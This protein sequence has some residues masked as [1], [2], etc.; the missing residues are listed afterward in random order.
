M[1]LAGI[2]SSG[3]TEPTGLTTKIS[4]PAREVHVWSVNLRVDRAA[5]CACWDLLSPEEAEIAASYRF[6]NDLRQFVV[7]RSLVRKILARYVD[8]SPLDLRFDFGASGKPVLRGIQSLHFN[9][10]HS[11]DLALLAIAH[12]PIGIDLEFIRVEGMLQAEVEQFLST[13][14]RSQL[15]QLSPKARSTALWRCWTR[16]EAALKAAGLG[17]RYPM[18]RLNVLAGS[19][20]TQIVRMMGRN[21]L[22]R[23]VVVSELYAAAVAIE[24]S[25]GRLWWRQWKLHGASLKRAVLCPISMPSPNHLS[26]GV[27]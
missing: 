14:E 6:A 10:S 5:V 13:S 11:R 21:W 19:K 27:M 17:L 3:H 15:R 20:D 26:G 9:V 24:H 23:Q 22:L 12:R 16:K 25:K 7:T 8:R 18:R 2:Q 1:F 4:L